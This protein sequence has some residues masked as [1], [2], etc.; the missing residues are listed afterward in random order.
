MSGTETSTKILQA[1][2]R[3]LLSDG[4]A[5]L[6]T[7][8]VAE[9]A[10]VPLSQI[11]YH[12]GSKE[13]MVLSLLRAENERLLDRQAEM[14]ATD[15]PLWRRWDLACDYLDEDLD[16][17]Y[18][19]V[20]QEMTAAGWSSEAVGKE[21]REMLMGWHEVLTTGARAAAAAG[22][23]LPGLDPEHLAMIVG[24]AFLG[25]EVKILLGLEEEGQHEREALRR[26]GDLIRVVE[27]GEERDEG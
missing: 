23:A 18:V 9:D 10:G 6:S 11:H 16:S 27:E 26:I 19:R 5:A 12:F 14:F 15:L 2:R 13:E 25:A 17:G 7:R 20:L 21:V 4:Y 24:S 1:A 8:K 22:L 3:C